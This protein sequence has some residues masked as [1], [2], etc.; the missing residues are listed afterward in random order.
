MND[1]R[2]NAGRCDIC[3]KRIS[4]EDGD[5]LALHEIGVADEVTEEYGVTDQDAADGVADALESVGDSGVDYDLAQ[6]IRE[7]RAFKAHSTCLEG[8]AYSK[9]QEQVPEGWTDDE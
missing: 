4:M 1:V 6:T 8:T 9:L 5:V 7:E 2:R 3:G